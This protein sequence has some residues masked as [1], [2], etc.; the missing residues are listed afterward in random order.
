VRL[1]VFHVTHTW[2]ISAGVTFVDLEIGL[3]RYYIDKNTG[4][5]ILA[6]TVKLI[7]AGIMG[8]IVTDL[9]TGEVVLLG[10]DE[11][12]VVL[13]TPQTCD[14]WLK[15]TQEAWP[16]ERPH[17]L[18]AHSLRDGR[19]SR[20]PRGILLEPI[21]LELCVSGQRGNRTP[22][23]RIFR[24]PVVD[25]LRPAADGQWSSSNDL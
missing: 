20:Q 11:V 24:A 25:L 12:P 18:G 17:T 1:E 14:A 5:L 13:L 19:S 2:R 6:S 8:Q 21:W 3:D 9:T 22:D 16:L 23:T 7:F 10:G 4:H 15:R